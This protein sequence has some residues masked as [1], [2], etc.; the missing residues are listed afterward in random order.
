MRE[1]LLCQTHF[2]W[3]QAPVVKKGT[4]MTEQ[5]PA[6]IQIAINTQYIK[7]FSFES[8][9]APHIFTPSA[10]APEVNVGVNVQTNTVGN[11]AFEVT[12]MIKIEAKVD[13][14]TAFITELAYAGVV[15]VPSLDEEQLKFVL[16]VEVPRILFPFA[17]G[18]L[19][20]AIRDGGF[21][22]LLLNPIDFGALYQAQ[23]SQMGHPVAGNA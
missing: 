8:P 6:P 15:S 2:V 17:R 10:A 22:Q 13:S 1:A 21:P 18:I 20:T 23:A 12:L 11:N 7:D 4:L 9:N 5:T 16:L 3:Y 14:K 19:A